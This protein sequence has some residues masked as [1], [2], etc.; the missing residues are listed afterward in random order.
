MTKYLEEKRAADP[1]FKLAEDGV[2]PGEMGHWLMAKAILLYLGQRV[3]DAADIKSAI[4]VNAHASEIYAIVTERQLLMK[5]A[6][7]SAA[8]PYA[9]GHEPGNAVIRS[10]HKI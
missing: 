4:A 3:E 7:L 9:A 8:G 5:D 6:W 10:A 2:H 1:S